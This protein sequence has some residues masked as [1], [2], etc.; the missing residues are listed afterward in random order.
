VAAQAKR[1][2][3]QS[4]VQPYPSSMIGASVVRPM[5][6]VAAYT[7]FANRGLR[8]EPFLVRRVSDA[9]G[10]VLL[11]QTARG[12]RT[13]SPEVAFLVTDLLKDAAEKGT[14]REARQRLPAAVPMAGKTGTTNDGTDVW[15]VG[16]TPEIVTGVWVGFDTPKSIGSAAYGSTLAAPIWGEM[17]REVYQKRKAPAAWAVPPGLLT[18]AADAAGQ[19]L[20]APCP[21]AAAKKEYFLA[22]AAPV[23]VCVERAGGLPGDW[24]VSDSVTLEPLGGEVEP[25]TVPAPPDSIVAPPQP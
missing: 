11:D 13:L 20:F 23:G 5:E 14:G 9:S 10:K 25:D 7:A 24:A 16:Y 1:Y 12:Y 15:Y 17:M 8:V 19:P 6:L 22:S 4:P 21:A 3:I 2:G 18:V